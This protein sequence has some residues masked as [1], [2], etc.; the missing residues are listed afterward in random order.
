[1][2]AD[3]RR[4]FAR[5]QRARRLVALRPVLIVGAFLTLGLAAGWML[6]YSNW[7]ALQSVDVNGVHLLTSRQI[8]RAAALPTGEA[9]V[10]L[11]LGA[12]TQRIEQI[13]AVGA[14][15]VSRS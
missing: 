15:T 4:Q 14:A 9:L 8:E 1:M 6:L 2:M 12:A 5:R 7:L 11:D 13:P 10:R 3:S